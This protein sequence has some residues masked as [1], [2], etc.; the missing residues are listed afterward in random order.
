[1][2]KINK[3]TTCLLIIIECKN[4]NK[5]HYVLYKTKK[6]LK[7]TTKKKRERDDNLGL[8]LSFFGR[9]SSGGI[10][11]RRWQLDKRNLLLV[12]LR[13]KRSQSLRDNDT[14]VDLIILQDGANRPGRGAHS[15]VEHVNVLDLLV[16]LLG[17]SVSDAQAT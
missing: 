14:I 13:H 2:V 6:K 7:R 15:G 3:K 8:L 9:C 16:H 12:P 17:L 10:F 11:R 1:M 4:L 5:S